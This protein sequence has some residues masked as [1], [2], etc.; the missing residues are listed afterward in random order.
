MLFH[1]D[2]VRSIDQLFYINILFPS[3]F[4]ANRQIMHSRHFSVIFTKSFSESSLLESAFAIPQNLSFLLITFIIVVVHLPKLVNL[5]LHKAFLS[6]DSQFLCKDLYKAFLCLALEHS[7][8]S[9]VKDF[10]LIQTD[11]VNTE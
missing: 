3:L 6:F 4:Q 8:A 9:A 5:A 11:V 1:E 2:V 7:P 10:G